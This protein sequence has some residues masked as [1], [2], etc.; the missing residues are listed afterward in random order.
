MWR[1][2][3]VEGRVFQLDLCHSGLSVFTPSTGSAD[4]T[5]DG[6][7]KERN[8]GSRRREDDKRDDPRAERAWR[9]PRRR[10]AGPQTDVPSR[11]D[12]RARSTRPTGPGDTW[13]TATAQGR[14][15][16]AQPVPTRSKE[17]QPST[18]VRNRRTSTRPSAD[19]AARIVRWRERVGSYSAGAPRGTKCKRRIVAMGSARG[20]AAPAPE[21]P[22]IC[23]TRA[24]HR[25]TA[26]RRQE[27]ASVSGNERGAKLCAASAEPSGDHAGPRFRPA[28]V[29]RRREAKR[30]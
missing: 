26:G 4:P 24:D 15:T 10:R 28:V 30:G 27:G 6:R 17:L 7:R 11:R 19:E 16:R 1:D 12:S 14:V 18:G 3:H 20:T 9:R 2:R 8:Q 23:A 5:P 29:G 22:A 25:R 13:M 21:R